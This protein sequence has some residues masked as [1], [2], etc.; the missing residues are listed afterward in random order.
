MRGVL[1][2]GNIV[3]DVLVRPVTE[4]RWNT[5]S[6]VDSI[7]HTM[8]GN[9]ANTA[10]ALA[11]L[12]TPVRLLGWVGTDAAGAALLERLSRAGVETDFVRRVNAP[13]ATTVSLVNEQGDRFLLHAPG[14]SLEAFREPPELAGPL[15]RGI[16]HVHLANLFAI[17]G[18]R[19]H[20]PAMLRWARQAGLRT[21]LDT[22]WDQHDR[23]MRDLEPALPWSDLV[24]VNREE[25]LALTGT[26][27]LPEAARAFTARGARTIVFKLGA[28]GCAL[29]HDGRLVRVP[30]FEVP[31]AD[32]TGAGDCFA[33]AFLAALARG[34]RWE[35]AA[36]FA[37]AAAALTVAELG[38][39]EGLRSW[40]EVQ[41]WMRTARPRAAG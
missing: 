3:F 14:V 6:W 26:A 40:D 20:G 34:L 4:L 24:F 41:R 27:D 22:G 32:T 13:T 29:W 5:T 15:V 23:W 19:R 39:T 38:A 31:V 25:T 12:G 2:L 21:S 8:G 36:R 9:G 7:R 17:P 1:C 30:A 37:N 10:Y 33:G 18:L 16:G 35:E 11:V 28:E